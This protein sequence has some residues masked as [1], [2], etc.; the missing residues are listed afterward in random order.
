MGRLA[1]GALHRVWGVAVAERLAPLDA[2]AL[3]R[4]CD[5]GQLPFETTR[6]V[7][8]A[9]E[10]PGH[11]RA[12]EALR[13]GIAMRQPGYH[14]FAL[15]APDVGMH[16]LVR[17]HLEK[18][19]SL[20]TTPADWVYVHRFAEPRRPRAI[21]LPA[22]TAPRLERELERLME[23]FEE[24]LP[25]AFEGGAY[26]AQLHLLEEQRDRRRERDLHA[27][28]EEA[29]ARGFA[30]VRTPMGFGVAPMRNGR[31]I[32]PDEI[33]DAPEEEKRRIERALDELV[34]RLREV[35]ATLPVAERAFVQEVTELSR[36]LARATAEEL[37]RELKA[38]YAHAPPVAAFLEEIVEDVQLHLREYLSAGD[39]EGTGDV[40]PHAVASPSPARPVFDR[41]RVSTLV[42]R[43]AA[44][45]APVVAIDAPSR[46]RLLGHIDYRT[47]YGSWLTDHTMVRGGALHEANGGYLLLDARKL[48]QQP[49][50]WEELKRA[51]RSQQVCMDAADEPH[52][53]S[54]PLS[55]E[56]EAIPLDV[57]VVL[58]GDRALYYALQDLDPEFSEL[59][60]VAADFEDELPRTSEN[61][62]RLAR[63]IAGHVERH[64]LLPFARE[65]VASLV[66]HASRLAGDS[67]KLSTAQRPLIEVMQEANH[68][69]ALQA[70]T[71]VA[72]EH[73]TDALEQRARRSARVK[74]RLREEICQGTLLIDTSGSAI[75]QVNALSVIHRGEAAFG[76]PVRITAR[77]RMGGG[78]IVDI[79][80]EAALAGP[81]HQKGVLILAGFLGQRY[82]AEEPLALAA[83][84]V[85][86]QSYGAIEGDS[87]SVAELIALLSAIAER[88]VRQF[89]A[90]TGSVNQHGRVQAVGG[91]NEK[92]EGF[93]DVCVAKGRVD[94][95]GVVFPAANARHLMLRPDVVAAAAEGRFQLWPVR[96]IDEVIELF[97]GAHAGERDA[98]GN[99]PPGSVNADVEA[100]LRRFTRAS[101]DYASR[102]YASRLEVRGRSPQGG[103]GGGDQEGGGS[104]S[105]PRR[106][107]G[108]H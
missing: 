46:A 40:A 35:A 72:R 73:V 83:S 39:V 15:G 26:Q 9:S 55:L 11:E 54:R 34:Q 23:Q 108:S 64:E 93:F 67:D 69:A 75:G 68:L 104:R 22:G 2:R 43:P 99:F 5:A 107:A 48:L 90:T 53:V 28:E 4:S 8:G 19:A 20:E 36:N 30:L 27:L 106:A 52:V 41:F 17:A 50:A 103:G 96:T 86:E 42:T 61:E 60:R 65:A 77:V 51:L 58:Y 98:E 92:I 81:I 62:V 91:I 18:A 82:S 29:R 59:F 63:C 57:K 10:G 21:A 45:G 71:I 37:V 79:E 31:P 25:R 14:I 6:D 24:L 101:Q 97:F 33:D 47:H 89:L 80:R 44:A 66:D 7:E 74:E 1:D 13:F 102:D 16:E 84:L 87:A 70:A 49:F 88:P 12:L 100:R 105:G 56:P 94:G 32:S 3:R 85:F 38:G 78:E 76:H 95:Q